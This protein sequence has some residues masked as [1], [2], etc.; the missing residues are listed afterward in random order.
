MRRFRRPRQFAVLQQ[1]L[2]TIVLLGVTI[3]LMLWRPQ[4]VS[5][6]GLAAGWALLALA[7]LLSI[8]ML[9]VRGRWLPDLVIPLLDFAA[10]GVCRLAT[11]P[12][13]AAISTLAFFPAIRLIVTYRGRGA[14]LS[15]A[16]VLLSITG[17]SL[18]NGVA[19]RDPAQI[20]LFAVLPIAVLMVSVLLA[21]LLAR[22]DLSAERERRSLR[23][24]L[25]A[26]QAA[27][28]SA[29]ILES[30][31]ETINVGFLILSPDGTPILQNPA[32][33]ALLDLMIPEGMT[34]DVPE[35]DYL[36]FRPDCRSRLPDADRPAA[37]LLRGESF[38]NMLVMVGPPGPAQRA[39]SI[40]GLS[41][42][43]MPD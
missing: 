5:M 23:A 29:A 43:A 6:P 8:A 1:G 13:G 35:K 40:S 36:I 4:S 33:R 18:V 39:I 3:M 2:F 41:S 10:L 27:A 20:S 14:A 26:T 37:R 25:D 34:D 21:N 15:V 17:P 9:Y 22:L 31:S 12:D 19:L 38:D 7:A 11:M 42:P 30:A 28:R 32:H 24:R 16:A